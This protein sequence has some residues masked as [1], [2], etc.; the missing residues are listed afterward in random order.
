MNDIKKGKPIDQTPKTYG[1]IPDEIK[2]EDHIFGTAVAD[3]ASK[4]ILNPTGDW[5]SWLPV[6]EH[7]AFSTETMA[8]TVFGTLNIVEVLI[9]QQYGIDINFSDRFLAKVSGVTRQGNSP[10]KVAEYLRKVGVP[11]Q[12][13]WDFTKEHDTWEKFYAEIPAKI[14]EEARSFL[15]QWEF[16]HYIVPPT[17]E[18]IK[19][20]LKFSPVGISVAAWAQNSGGIYYQFGT[21]N[22]WTVCYNQRDVYD[23]F[24]SYDSYTKEYDIQAKPMIAKGYYVKKKDANVRQWTLFENIIFYLK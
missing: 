5:F 7:Q 14:Y 22:H 13:L 23:I 16:K 19:D 12:E 6:T 2:P 24:D 8:C 1:F 11:K 10:H 18:A 9:K 17:K 4:K 20:A 3:Y 21:D 15:A